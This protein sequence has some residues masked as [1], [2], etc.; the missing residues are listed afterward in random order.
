ML[1]FDQKWPK[2]MDKSSGWVSAAGRGVCRTRSKS[3]RWKLSAD[4]LV[5]DRS[6][7]KLLEGTIK[8]FT[9]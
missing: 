9:T 3:L 7:W 5:E 4:T 6:F 1:G 8:L 2:C